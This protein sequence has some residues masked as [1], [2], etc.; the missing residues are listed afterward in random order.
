VLLAKSVIAQARLFVDNFRAGTDLAAA[1]RERVLA[2]EIARAEHARAELAEASVRQGQRE[3]AIEGRR[4][5]MVM[6]AERFEASVVAAV[7]ALGRAAQD[8]RRSAETLMTTSTVQARDVDQ[9]VSVAKR[10]SAAADTMRDTALRLSA[11]VADVARRVSDQA[12]LTADAADG[13]REGERVISELIEDAKGVGTIVALIGDI[14][15]QTNLLALNATIEAARAGESG[16]GFA[17]VATEVKSLAAQTSRATGEIERQIAAMQKRV[18]TVA[19]V[20]DGILARVGDVSRLA[21]DIRGA[22]D[23]QTRVT[24]SIADGAHATAL[25]SADLQA[26]VEGAARASEAAK[27]L[28]AGVAGSTADI[29]GQIADLATTT[30]AFLAELRAA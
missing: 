30:Q 24:A 9:V 5:D 17:V 10:T 27:A 2:E 13:T 12:T 18:M 19:Q 8:T 28:T 1:A 21:A 22:A 15:G 3:R 11:S 6:L 29:V 25:G 20:I 26:G 23:D 16:R 4:A 14:A 7:A